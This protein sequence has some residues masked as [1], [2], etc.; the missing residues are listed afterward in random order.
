MALINMI[1]ERFGKLSVDSRADN[2]SDG[3]ATWKCLCDCGNV[4]KIP[5][6]KLRAGLHKSCGCAS[7]RFT[8]ERLTTHGKSRS[9]IYHI[10]QGMI[11]RTTNSNNPKFHLYGGKGIQVCDAWRKFEN[12][13]NDMGDAPAF[14][15]IDRIDGTKGYYKDNCRWANSKQQA[16]NK[17][18][19][20]M[21]TYDGK[22][23]TLSSWA[24]E[25]NIL[26]NTLVYRLKRGWEISR[27]LTK[28]QQ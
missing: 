9:R 3:T 5:G 18:S 2:L 4:R 11:D 13:Y 23:Q 22:T 28:K 8:S 6:N 25:I 16:N 7:P 14:L 12:F 1:G 17:S 20:R 26:P 19:N 24:A 15:S 10:W 21:I 27:A